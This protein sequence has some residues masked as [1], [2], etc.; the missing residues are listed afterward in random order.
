MHYDRVLASQE[1]NAGVLFNKA[2][3]LTAMGKVVE[4]DEAFLLAGTIDPRYA[5]PKQM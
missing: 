2:V 5:K 3:A 1:S 4:A